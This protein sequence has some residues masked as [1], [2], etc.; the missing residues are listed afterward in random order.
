VIDM[1]NATTSRPDGIGRDDFIPIPW[2][3]A[4]PPHESN[5][6]YAYFTSFMSRDSAPIS[7]EES[8]FERMM[9][10]L[11]ILL[12]FLASFLGTLSLPR[13][14]FGIAQNVILFSRMMRDRALIY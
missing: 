4:A 3:F 8:L 1:R 6:T 11:R 2:H 10:E 14:R 5:S 9:G 13:R 12:L 7:T